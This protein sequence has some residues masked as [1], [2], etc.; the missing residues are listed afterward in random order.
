MWNADVTQP[1]GFGIFDPQG[2][3]YNAT[4]FGLQP[5]YIGNVVLG[6][7]QIASPTNQTLP[8]L[9][10]TGAGS[11]PYD[12]SGFGGLPQSVFNTTPDNNA[13][14]PF[15]S[16]T[17]CS[18]WD[19]KC[20]WKGAPTWLGGQGLEPYGL[21]GVPSGGTGSGATGWL[22]SYFI[23]FAIIILGFI[24]VAAGLF[25]FQGKN[26]VVETAKAIK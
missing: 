12:I 25:M 21:A 20:Q 1:V 26:I 6:P 16:Q 24:F 23:R 10:G 11:N 14:K 13:S 5:Q 15:N 17:D 7:T 22:E 9:T 3:N 8:S 2:S 19:I 18:W 4:G